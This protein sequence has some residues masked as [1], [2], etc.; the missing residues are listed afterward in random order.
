ME[1]GIPKTIGRNKWYVP[2]YI[3][4]VTTFYIHL[5]GTIQELSKSHLMLFETKEL[6][7]EAI[8]RQNKVIVLGGE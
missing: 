6:A 8:K 4:G 1:I 5:D 2:V 7:L 3:D